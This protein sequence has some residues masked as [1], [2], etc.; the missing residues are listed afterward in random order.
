MIK[1]VEKEKYT[2]C[3]VEE[4]NEK[5]KRQSLYVS[6][7]YDPTISICSISVRIYGNRC[8]IING[9]T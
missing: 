1:I 2:Q 9:G 3:L 8:I 5:K 7:F 6:H 4:L